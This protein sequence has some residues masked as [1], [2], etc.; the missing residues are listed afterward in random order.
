MPCYEW[1]C[2][3]CGHEFETTQKMN[4]QDPVCPKCLATVKKQISSSSFQLKGPGWAADNYS[5][6][7]K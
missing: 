2:L 1:K 4:D 7:K 6:E 3:E 5:K